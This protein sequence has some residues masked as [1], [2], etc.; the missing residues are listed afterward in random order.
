MS[1]PF[2]AFRKLPAFKKFLVVLTL[3]FFVAACGVAGFW[4]AES[5]AAEKLQRVFSPLGTLLT[6]KPEEPTDFPNPLNGVLYKASEA[7]AWKDLLPLAVIIENHTEARPQSG[8]QRA[9][10]TYEV[11]AEGG[12]TR[13][14]NIY[15]AQETALGPVRSNRTYF[16]DWV[17]EYGAGYSH[18]G[19]SPEAQSKVQSYKIKDLDQFSVGSEA[20]Q[21]VS[22]RF[23]PHNVYTSTAKLRAAAKRRGYSGPVQ[24]AMWNFKD[25]EATS[26]AR[27]AKFNVKINFGSSSLPDYRV[28]WRY[29][30]V[31]NTYLRLNGGVAHL[32]AT[33]KKQ[34]SAKNIIVQYLVT[35]PDP[36]GHSR[37]RMQTRGSGKAIIFRDGRA[38]SANWRKSTLTSRTRFYDT[39]GN[40]IALNRGKIWIEI[41][42]TGSLVRYN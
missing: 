14:M 23:A 20:Y 9:E 31:T 27:P 10:I 12:I 38:Y 42:P 8:M 5:K 28:E 6:G 34:L 22:S 7:A 1:N 25:K 11:L 24:I 18:V 41:V 17:S 19:G 35:T 30:K 3:V 21:R 37:L 36:S 13:T 16:L 39:K 15:L 4:F 26:G 29:D 40:E 33:N 32:D 2:R